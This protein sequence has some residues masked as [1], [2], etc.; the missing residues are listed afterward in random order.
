MEQTL[1]ELRVAAGE[2]AVIQ[3]IGGQ[4]KGPRDRLV[5]AMWEAD[6]VTTF[7]QKIADQNERAKRKKK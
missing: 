2:F 4:M 5:T 7:G 1:N 6:K 3:K